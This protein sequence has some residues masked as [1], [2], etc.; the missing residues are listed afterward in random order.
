MNLNDGFKKTA[1][2]LEVTKKNIENDI[3]KTNLDVQGLQIRNEAI[4]V[5]MSNVDTNLNNFDNSLKKYF[6]FYDSNTAIQNEKLFNH[7]FSGINP[8]LELMAK[9]NS[10]NGITLTTPANIIDEHNLKICNDLQHCIH[11]NVNNNG[12][13]I[14]PD[15]V[16]GLT[17][18]SKSGPALAKFDMDKNGIYLGGVDTSAPLFIEDGNLFVNNI[19]LVIRPENDYN[20]DNAK[21]LRITGT[22]M[23]ALQ[24]W[25]CNVALEI[26]EQANIFTSQLIPA[27]QYAEN[28]YGEYLVMKNNY[29]NIAQTIP[30]LSSNYNG[31]FE[32]KLNRLNNIQNSFPL[33][34]SKVNYLDSNYSNIN[35]VLRNMPLNGGSTSNAIS[36]SAY[37][38][39]L[40]K[41]NNLNDIKTNYPTLVSRVQGIESA[42]IGL[43]ATVG[44]LRTSYNDITTRVDSLETSR[45][46][47]H[48]SITGLNNRYN[49]LNTNVTN[50]TNQYNTLNT[51]VTGLNTNVTNLTNQYSLLNTSVTGLNTNVSN[52]NTSVTEIKNVSIPDL[53]A[54]ISKL[55]QYENDIPVF[56]MTYNATYSDGSLKNNLILKL[57]NRMPINAGDRLKIRIYPSDIGNLNTS[58]VV[59]GQTIPF[60]PK[61][62]TTPG[63][64]VKGEYYT[65]VISPFTLGSGSTITKT[66]GAC[67]ITIV[68]GTSMPVYSS[69]QVTISGRAML[70]NAFDNFRYGFVIGKHNS[71]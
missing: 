51:S 12:F 7:V 14:T 61:L 13:N 33:L 6:T 54:K 30:L 66:N 37:T 15:N 40:S 25:S 4:S 18:N 36:T 1:Q 21:V 70:D 69:I 60:V 38:D 31:D 63:S 68:S 5:Q 41:V 11:L 56:F 43:N 10:T 19:N 50:L 44:G 35:T 24:K 42:N 57:M 64:T 49:G 9:V 59:N 58:Y 45:S 65:E 39:L 20:D 23:Y 47:I 71:A 8:D 67:E 55:M 28:E 53:V 52:L 29:S 17:I 32:S 2:N 22:E 62:V 26:I 34:E 48:D 27:I 46:G 16:G 3:D